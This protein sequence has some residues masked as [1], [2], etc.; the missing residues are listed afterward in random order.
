M[1]QDDPMALERWGVT[2][3]EIAML[4]SQFEQEPKENRLLALKY[5]DDIS[6]FR[7]Q[8]RYDVKKLCDLPQ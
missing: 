4:I 5:H 6:A 1:N 7:K 3:L 2:A 8:Y